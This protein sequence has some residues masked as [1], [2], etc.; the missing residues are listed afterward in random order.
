MVAVWVARM[1]RFRSPRGNAIRR[2][3]LGMVALALQQ[4]T[5]H[6]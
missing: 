4:Q 1:L 6:N 3:S 2:G 5:V